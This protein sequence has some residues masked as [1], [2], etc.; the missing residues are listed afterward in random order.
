MP[1]QRAI[2]VVKYFNPFMFHLH[3]LN[4]S[5]KGIKCTICSKTNCFIVP[6]WNVP[7]YDL[8]KLLH[9]VNLSNI[10]R[11]ISDFTVKNKC[12]NSSDLFFLPEGEELTKEFQPPEELDFEAVQTS[13]P[14]L[15]YPFVL[16]MFNK[17]LSN[18]TNPEMMLLANIIHIP[19]QE[20]KLPAELYLQYA[21]S[22][23]G[24]LGIV[25]K[26]YPGSFESSQTGNE[27]CVV[28]MSRE[29]S[30]V[31]VPC[32]H[33][34]LCQTCFELCKNCPICRGPIHYYFVSNTV[35]QS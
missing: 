22:S 17:T 33:I 1:Q 35:S 25:K 24:Y 23:N 16:I 19:D 20:I 11:S 9:Q 14:R 21:K 2:E 13:C 27:L 34:C 3:N 30:V 4:A 28:C 5:Y 6:L 29:I 8:F 31:V 32:G 26:I 10:N 12:G 18:I 7:I 15:K